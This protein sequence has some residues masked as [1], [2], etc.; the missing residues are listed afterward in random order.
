MEHWDWKQLRGHLWKQFHQCIPGLIPGPGA[1]C[2]INFQSK[3]AFLLHLKLESY[4]WLS[5]LSFLYHAC[6]RD[7][8]INIQ[9][10]GRIQ[11]ERG[12][13]LTLQAISMT[14]NLPERGRLPNLGVKWTK[15]FKKRRKSKGRVGISAVV[16]VQLSP[17]EWACII[18]VSNTLLFEFRYS[19]KA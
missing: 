5:F 17:I 11:T 18:H 19:H 1:V 13:F 14:Q 12:R 2:A 7:A 6:C 4:H 3:L 16:G 10:I 9:K 8:N 15:M